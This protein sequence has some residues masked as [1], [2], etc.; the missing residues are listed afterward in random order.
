MSTF[1]FRLPLPVAAIALLASLAAATPPPESPYSVPQPAFF[2]QVRTRTEFDNKAVLDSSVNK[3]M[4]STHLRA[5]L[6]FLATPSEKVEIKVEFQDVRFFGSEPSSAPTATGAT[7]VGTAPH[8]ATV[9][10]SKGVDL[11]QGYVAI[12]EGPVKLAIGRQKMS[13]GAGR[14]LST[15]EWSPTSRA[16][17]GGSFNWSLAGGD[18]T[19]FGFLVRDTLTA[20]AATSTLAVTDDRLTLAGL[21]YNRKFGENI[22]VEGGVFYDKSTI[23]STMSGN[24]F[25]RYDLVYIDQRVSGQIG[26]FAFD[27]EFIYQA[28]SAENAAATSLTS[29][30]YQVALRAGVVLPKIKA[31]VGLDLMSGDDDA[32]DDKTTHYRANY[33]F[34]H[35]YYGWMDYFT[36]NPAFG[37][38]DYRADVDALLWQG[39]ARSASLKAQYHYF[40]P[41]SAPSGLDDPYGQEINAEI[42]LG[43]YPRSNIVIGAG[44]FIPGDMAFAL[45]PARTL[46]GAD[47]KAGYFFYFMPV[48]NF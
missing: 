2:G 32:T 37:V 22:T 21:Y 25:R 16:F 29:S 36:I 40:T 38:I 10:N 43:L 41:H 42:H 48:F 12:Q 14:Y 11:L 27:E 8:T 20:T 7:P 1:T 31:N 39:E 30:A 5:R 15:L 34:A 19:G 35:A 23:P 9:G 13:L 26:I 44:V 18:L 33:Y 28:G 3:S 24:A 6:G 17:D 46:A 4:A 47:T 45:T